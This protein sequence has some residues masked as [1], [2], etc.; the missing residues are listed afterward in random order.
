MLNISNSC[1]VCHRWSEQ[2]IRD[3]VE[4]IQDKV[5]EGRR[6]AE[7]V[8]A[9]AHLDVAA[10]MQAGAGDEQLQ[11]VRS[12]I[13][14]AQLR[15]D[16]VAAN[17]GMGFHSPAECLRILAAAVDLGGQA[18][19][20]CAAILGRQGLPSR[21]I[22]P[23]SAAKGEGP[24]A[25]QAVRGRPSAEDAAGKGETDRGREE[26]ARHTIS[27]VVRARAQVSQDLDNANGKFSF[28]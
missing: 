3:R 26:V 6:R 5:H 11:S 9:K 23:T 12:L 24:S 1:A 13:R 22:I 20:D 7:E 18:R 8:L 15:W 16:F 21:S 27:D 10:A 19:V 14:Q 17:N 4:S 2:E 28:A 25:G